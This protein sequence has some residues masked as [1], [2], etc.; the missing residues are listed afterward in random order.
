MKITLLVLAL[1]AL[2]SLFVAWAYAAFRN[3]KEPD[4]RPRRHKGTRRHWRAFYLAP[5]M[6]E[7][8]LW[9]FGFSREPRGGVQFANIGEGTIEHG[10]K[11]YI[12]DAG[13]TSR[14]LLYKIGSDADHCAVTGAGDTPLGS[15]DDLADANNLDLP[16]AIKLF[17]AVKGTTLVITDGTVANGNRVKAGAAGK[18]TVAA[19]ADLSFGI[20]II[21][22]DASS[23]AGDP[24]QII[25]CVPQ[26]YAF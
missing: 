19:T 2:A 21:P 9:W 24:I 22:T 12:P 20:A 7:R 26:K 1:I 17:G 25:S 18:V 23:A 4:I 13:T 3:A 16:I 6:I 8:L 10:V 14:Y 5:L 15:S 11:S